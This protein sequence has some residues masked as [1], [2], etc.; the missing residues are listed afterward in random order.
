MICCLKAGIL[1]A[2]FA[3][4][5]HL[6]LASSGCDVVVP[7]QQALTHEAGIFLLHYTLEGGGALHDPEDFNN[8]GVPDVVEDAGLQLRVMH[9]L[10]MYFGFDSPLALP[11]YANQGAKV[12]HV[13]FVDMKGNGTAMDEPRTPR[14][15][16]C[17]LLIN[18]STKL[19]RGNLTPAH[20][21]FHLVQYAYVPYKRAWYLEGMARWSETLLGRD[22]SFGKSRNKSAHFKPE[23]IFAM[24]YDAYG[25]FWQP[26]VQESRELHEHTLPEH[27][28]QARYSRGEPV[29][30]DSRV[31]GANRMRAV[32]VALSEQGMRDS[33]RLGLRAQ[34]WPEKVQRDPMHDEAIWRVLQA[35]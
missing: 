18:L 15:Q 30:K 12:V 7:K 24:S 8:N 26:F 28:L 31:Y 21:Y 2:V 29:L 10:L 22:V 17:G 34:A 13:R 16:S 6:A 35:L 25:N 4:L 23:Q 3:L 20:E 33:D 11:R 9:E 5:P 32:L 1:G 19:A 14:G 27:L